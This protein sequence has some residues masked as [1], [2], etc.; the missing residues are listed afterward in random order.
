MSGETRSEVS[1]SP[2][3]VQLRSARVARVKVEPSEVQG[4]QPTSLP[5]SLSLQVGEVGD[6]GEFMLM[7]EFGTRIP[8]G[9]KYQYTVDMTVEGVF[10]SRAD[11]PP[12]SE[13]EQ[14][15]FKGRDAVVLLWPYL[16]VFLGN[17]LSSV[18]LHRVPPL[19]MIDPRT[20]L[21]TRPKPRA[22]TR[23]SQS[24]KETH[25]KGGQR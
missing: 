4:K 25:K 2:F 11:V 15:Q 10:E 23:R 14:L 22:K 3:A 7:M 16:R 21:E 13:A 8:L 12:L 20:L 1:F 17:L 9:E 24:R 18:G 6:A 5:M 19:P